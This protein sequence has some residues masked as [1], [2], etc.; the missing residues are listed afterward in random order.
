MNMWNASAMSSRIAMSSCAPRVRSTG[1]RTKS[2]SP[3]AA[4]AAPGALGRAARG[5]GS[6]QSA[7]PDAAVSAAESSSARS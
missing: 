4:P 5:L 6:R 1:S 3:P 7:A 2:I